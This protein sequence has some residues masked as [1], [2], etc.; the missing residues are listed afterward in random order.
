MGAP[1]TFERIAIKVAKVL[2]LFDVRS[3]GTTPLSLSTI[4][5][6]ILKLEIRPQDQI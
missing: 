3:L 4:V 6:S 1:G 2:N 5:E